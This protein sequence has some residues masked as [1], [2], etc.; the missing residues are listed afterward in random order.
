MLWRQVLIGLLLFAVYLLVDTLENPARRAAASQHGRDIFELEQR[1]HIDIEHALNNWLAPHRLLSTLANYEYAWTYILSAL[2]LLAWTYLRRPDLWKLTRDS[3][4]VL[5]LIAFACFW[6]Y[7]TAPPRLLPGLGFVD[8][9][10]RGDTVGSWGNSLVDSANQ[11]AAMPSLHVG[12]ALWVSVVLARIT[13][14]RW[15]QVLSAAHV[16]LTAFVIMATAN[17]YLLDA[18]AVII[19]IAVG[20]RVASWLH[21]TPGVVVPSCDAFFLH[22]EDTGAAQHVGGLVLLEP[23]GGRPS[24]EEVRDLVRDGLATLPRMHQ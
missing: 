17:H 23:S 7:P 12:W 2:A 4:I 6:L 14:S 20:V 10:S 3:F 18:I 8:T 24:M 15:V 13:A 9:V 16:A 22:V 11:L 21:E 5:N 19:P 1:L